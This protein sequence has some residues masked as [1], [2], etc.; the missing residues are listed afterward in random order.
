MEW[1]NDGI[2]FRC[3]DGYIVDYKGKCILLENLNII[4]GCEAIN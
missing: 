1:D 2:C 3:N 4:L